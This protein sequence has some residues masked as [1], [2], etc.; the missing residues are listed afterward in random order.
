MIAPAGE[1]ERHSALRARQ[2]ADLKSRAHLVA[3]HLRIDQFPPDGVVPK[4]EG[5]E[6]HHQVLRH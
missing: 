4:I 5:G 1:S 3:V 2:G 6:Y